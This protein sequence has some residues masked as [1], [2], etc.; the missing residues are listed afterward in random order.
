MFKG[1][2][3][4]YDYIID[5][6]REKENVLH[7]IS[8]RGIIGD[9]SVPKW[10][11]VMVHLFRKHAVLISSQLKLPGTDNNKIDKWIMHP[12]DE[13]DTYSDRL[14]WDDDLYTL[15]A[16]TVLGRLS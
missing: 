3:E 4:K 5:P 9:E 6:S 8:W 2:K 14:R 7:I 10:G 16:R 11:P 15:L 12:D 1:V 13:S